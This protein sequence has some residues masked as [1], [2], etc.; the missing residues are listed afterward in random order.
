MCKLLRAHGFQQVRSKGDHIIMQRQIGDNDTITVPVPL[1]RELKI[2]T[3]KSII[4]QSQLDREL[5]ET[6]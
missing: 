2:G 4:R 6:D 1:H 5:F 3:L